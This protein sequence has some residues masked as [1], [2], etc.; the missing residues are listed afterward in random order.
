MVSV[1]P[2]RLEDVPAIT[3]IQNELHDTAAIAWTD[4]RRKRSTD[5]P[6][7]ATIEA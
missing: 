5:E 3:D 7:S 6:A 1:R 4:E 2:A